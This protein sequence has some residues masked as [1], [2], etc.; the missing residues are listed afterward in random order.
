MQPG[1]GRGGVPRALFGPPEAVTD[2]HEHDV[3]PADPDALVPLG[4]EQIV[5]RHVVAR[6]QP[7]HAAGARH[8]QQH[9]AADDAVGGD[10]RWTVRPPRSR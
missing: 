6:L 3:A 9:P 4:R 1:P 5:R 7:R 8:I 2:P 10:R